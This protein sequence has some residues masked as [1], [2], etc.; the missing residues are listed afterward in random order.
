MIIINS[1]SDVEKFFD[2]IWM[3]LNHVITDLNFAKNYNKNDLEDIYDFIKRYLEHGKKDMMDEIKKGKK[4]SI[5]END[6]ILEL[7]KQFEEGIQGQG[8]LRSLLLFNGNQIL[9]EIILRIRRN[10]YSKNL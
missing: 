4:F 2:T 9:K 5:P 10:K 3:E 7:V 1:L 8:L 6:F